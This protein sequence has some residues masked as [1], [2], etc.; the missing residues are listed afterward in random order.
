MYQK[1][2]FAGVTEAEDA[3]NFAHYAKGDYAIADR[4]KMPRINLDCTAINRGFNEA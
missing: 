1:N 3:D 4:R 2:G